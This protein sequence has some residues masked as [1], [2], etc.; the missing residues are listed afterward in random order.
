MANK[1]KD[2]GVP[3]LTIKEAARFLGIS[4]TDFVEWMNAEIRPSHSEWTRFRKEPGE[5]DWRPIPSAI[6]RRYI[7]DHGLIQPKVDAIEKLAAA[8]LKER[9]IAKR[10]EKGI[11]TR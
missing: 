6:I 9:P 1:K 11:A 7:M 10:K 5:K 3:L 4:V 8:L 2:Y